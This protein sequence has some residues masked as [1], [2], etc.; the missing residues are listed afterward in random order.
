MITINR[1]KLQKQK[2]HLI[3]NIL[4][5]F[6]VICCVTYGKYVCNVMQ[7]KMKFMMQVGI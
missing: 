6:C 7:W 3:A 1:E 2:K 4:A 5:I